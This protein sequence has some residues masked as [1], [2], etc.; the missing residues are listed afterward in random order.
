MSSSK[1]SLSN[2]KLTSEFHFKYLGLWV[3]IT[4]ALMVSNNIVLFLWIQEHFLEALS[5]LSPMHVR[6][7]EMKNTIVTALVVE[8]ILF[9][10][11]VIFL[12]KLTAHRIAGPYIRLQKTFD[13][14]RSGNAKARLK[15][16]DYDSLE[17]LAEAFN[18]MM[19]DVSTGKV[20]GAKADGQ[21]TGKDGA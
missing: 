3:V 12:A 9:G 8:T 13:A 11:G 5:A 1:R 14:V 6:F 10:V 21:G 17:F 2:L 20:T 16:R 4:L 18:G 7:I 19:D 15:F